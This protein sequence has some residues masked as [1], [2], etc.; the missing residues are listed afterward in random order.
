ME[1]SVGC[2]GWSYRHWRDGFY[3]HGL[4]TS[5]WFA[6][7][8]SV[9]NTVELN[10]T[11]Y[12]L[13]TEKAVRSWHD[14][15]TP[16]FA[17]AA[18]ASRLITHFR[19]LADCEEALAAYF[20]RIELLGEHLGPILYQLPPNF[21]RDDGVLKRFLALLPAVRRHVFEFRHA[22]WWCDEVF[23][24][25]SRHKAGFCI[26]DMAQTRTPFIATTDFAYMRFH[27]PDGL[28]RGGY[29]EAELTAVA[30][31]LKDLDGAERV[32]AYFNNDLRGQAPRDALTFRRLW[33]DTSSDMTTLAST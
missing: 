31:K 16:A 3:P 33:T 12:R 18:K 17:F 26:Y 13:P 23:D 32:F 20:E 14:S 19:R 4:P 6:H 29:E 30:R 28:G 9:F 10:G 11:F 15:A 27:G 2:S 25:L 7:Y 22:S 24:L 5:R 21:E 1:A 8:A